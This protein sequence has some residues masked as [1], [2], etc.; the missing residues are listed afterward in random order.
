MIN[1]VDEKVVLLYIK[2]KLQS[3]EEKDMS[4]S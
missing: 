2:L 1:I 3:C 4:Y